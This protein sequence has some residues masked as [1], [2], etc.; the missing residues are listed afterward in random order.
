MK[1]FKKFFEYYQGEELLKFK[2]GNKDPNRLGFDKKHLTTQNKDYA[3]KNH[4]VSNLMKGSASQIKLMGL[5]LQHLLKDY[6]VE[7]VPGQTK[8]LG[9]SNIECKMYEDEEGN[10]CGIITRK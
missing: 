5:P 2:V 9:N 8:S 6:E 4:H 3:H 10:S 7:Y 1:S